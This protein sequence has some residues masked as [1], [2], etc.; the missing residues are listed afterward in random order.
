MAIASLP[1]GSA[2]PYLVRRYVW[3]LP[4]VRVL[5]CGHSFLL[6]L[7]L[8]CGPI[9]IY[10][11]DGMSLPYYRLVRIVIR[12][13]LQYV[14]DAQR[15]RKLYIKKNYDV[16]QYSTKN[17][18]SH[19]C[20]MLGRIRKQFTNAINEKIKFPKLCIFVLDNDLKRHLKVTEKS[21]SAV[22]AEIIPW[23]FNKVDRHIKSRKE[24]LPQKAIKSEYPMIYWMEAPQH[25]NFSEAD[26]IIRHKQN[27]AI[28]SE[29]AR[30]PYMKIVRMKK[31]WDPE[32]GHLYANNRYSAEGLMKYWSSIDNAIEYHDMKA[33]MK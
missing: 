31:V 29:V 1:Y 25:I 16:F 14:N 2:R 20:S 26:N 4:A 3:V 18:C 30:Y 32:D 28:Q 19:V 8:L 7:W 24:Q 21:A 6:S 27:S 5:P 15:S 17:Y 11:G 12:I 23:L 22:F 13:T 9:R 10:L 33:D